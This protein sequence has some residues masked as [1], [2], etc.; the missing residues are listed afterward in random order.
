MNRQVW[1]DASAGVAGD[2][3]LGALLDAG[4]DLDTVQATV[5]AVIPAAVRLTSNVV[6]RAGLRA[7]KADVDVLAADP[8]HRTWRAIQDLLSAADLPAAVR[9]NATAVFG[10]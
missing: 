10:R 8:P 2:M 7:T 1:V 9:D 4:A 5:D 6:S 3:L